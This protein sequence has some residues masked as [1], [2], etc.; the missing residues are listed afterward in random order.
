MQKVKNKRLKMILYAA[1]F[2]TV[3]LMFVTP[4]YWML[5]SSFKPSS[6]IFVDSLRL[7]PKTPTL[8]NYKELSSTLFLRWFI[9]S[10]IFVTGYVVIGLFLCSLAGFAFS[11]YDFRFKNLIFILIIAAQMLPIHLLLIPLFV[12][13]TKV[14]LINTYFGLIL[15]MVANPFGLFFIRQY[16]DGISND[17]L[18]AARIDGASEWQ[19]FYKIM[20]PL[21]KPAL[22][23]LAILF[24]LFAWNDLIWP[25]IAMRT[26]NMFTLSVGLSSLIGQYR[27][28]Y[29]LLMAGSVLTVLP[30][31]ALFL[32]MQEHF[33]S[34][35]T[36]GSVKG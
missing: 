19:L 13:L 5:V 34:G 4:F 33:I 29:S 26:E 3:C 1:F 30:I 12:M 15:P 10:G 8:I 16:M 6:E 24:A 2:I 36:A 9:N 17:I 20:L 22:A 25:L 18:N 21:S 35:L 7:L 23:A 14:G 27:P 11:K 28:R 32:K 31:V